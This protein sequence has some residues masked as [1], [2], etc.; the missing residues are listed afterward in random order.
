MRGRYQQRRAWGQSRDPFIEPLD[1][2]GGSSAIPPFIGSAWLASHDYGITA[3]LNSETGARLHYAHGARRNRKSAILVGLDHVSH[4]FH[5]TVDGAPR[6]LDARAVVWV[7]RRATL[8]PF[9]DAI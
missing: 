8:P 9:L 7:G 2:L 1:T 4:R 6:L 3:P 5:P